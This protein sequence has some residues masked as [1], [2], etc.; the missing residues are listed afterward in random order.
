M[1][2]DNKDESKYRTFSYCFYSLYYLNDK[3]KIIDFFLR[4]HIT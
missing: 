4:Q 1:V 3:N 2:K